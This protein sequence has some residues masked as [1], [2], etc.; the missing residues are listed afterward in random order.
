MK[1]HANAKLTPQGRLFLVQR[2]EKGMTVTEAA[3]S[4]GVSNRTAY[5][6]LRRYRDEGES[7]LRDRSSRPH[8]SPGKTGDKAIRRILHL[9]RQGRVAWEIARLVKIPRSTV[10]RI[11]RQNGLGRLC[12][13]KP[14]EEVRRYERERPGELLHID[15][16]K[17]G[18]IQGGPGHRVHGNRV[19]RVQGAGWENAHAA[20]DDHTRLAYAEVLPDEGQESVTVFLKRA[21]AWYAEQGIRIERV[22]TDQGSGYRSKRF[23]RA[24]EEL[25]IRHIYTRPYT[26]KTNG[27]VERFIQTMSRKWAYAKAYR[28]SKKRD[29]ALPTWIHYYNQDRP[30]HGLGGL[31]P[32]QRLKRAA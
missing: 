18:R 21:V 9:R 32:Y 11:L 8:R 24:C 5:R 2:I 25:G 19:G 14:R 10:S 12:F 17:L 27:K 23:N 3:A 1:I 20:V 15:T 22:L 26:P 7:G 30:H 16:K 4:V 6:W 29:S 31:T 28:S 13:L